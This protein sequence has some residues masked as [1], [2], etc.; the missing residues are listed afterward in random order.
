M[1]HSLQKAIL[2]ELEQSPLPLSGATLRD[3]LESKGFVLDKAS[4]HQTGEALVAAGRI[5]EAGVY[6]SVG[7]MCWRL[8]SDEER[9]PARRVITLG[10]ELDDA[11]SARFH[12]LDA[13]V[14][15]ELEDDVR[16]FREHPQRFHRIRHAFPAE[17]RQAAILMGGKPLGDG[18]ALFMAV[19]RIAKQSNLRAFLLGPTDAPVNVP[20]SWAAAIFA[21]AMAQQGITRE[22]EASAIAAYLGTLATRSRA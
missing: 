19:E 2:R 1:S 7:H 6:D 5:A 11:T 13:E 16:F 10:G 15:R 17:A 12:A 20:E 8:V 18:L 21:V 14:F 4:L 22:H 9:S 3:R